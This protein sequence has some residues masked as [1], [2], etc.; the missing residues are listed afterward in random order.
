MVTRQEIED[1]IKGKDSLIKIDYLKRYLRQADSMDIK[2]FILLNLAAA[3]ESR[4]LLN[5]AVKNVASAGDISITYREKRELYMKEVSLWIKVGDFIMAEKAFHK[6]ISYG[7]ELERVEMQ[8][9]YEDTFMAMGKNYEDSGKFRKALEIYERLS[10]MTKT[11]NRKLE[12]REKL[13]HLYGKLGRIREY[14]RMKN[15]KFQ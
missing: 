8:S 14:N 4:G 5:D 2:R 13:L 15:A 10:Q 6:A 7:S 9:L 11:A 3:N 1:S 12:T